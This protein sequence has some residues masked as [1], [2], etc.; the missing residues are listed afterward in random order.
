ME[1]QQAEVAGAASQFETA[2]GA[3]PDK[4]LPIAEQLDIAVTTI[5]SNMKSMLDAKAQEAFFKKVTSLVPTKYIFWKGWGLYLKSIFAA[6]VG[7]TRVGTKCLLAIASSPSNRARH[8][9]RQAARTWCDGWLR[10]R[11]GR[12]SG[13][14]YRATA[15]G[16]RKCISRDVINILSNLIIVDHNILGA[17]EESVQ[18]L[19]VLLQDAR[20]EIQKIHKSHEDE[21]G[22]MQRKF[23]QQGRWPIQTQTFRSWRHE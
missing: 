7:R 18:K 15:A 1:R 5:K 16:A 12:A 23:A 10:G 22:A 17:Q 20:S 3:L 14:S 19:Q 11:E 9:R 6:A 8:F 21:L 2:V 4:N 13:S